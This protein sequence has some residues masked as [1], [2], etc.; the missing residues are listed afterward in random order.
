MIRIG[1]F[2]VFL[3]AAGAFAFAFYA[4]AA[5]FRFRGCPEQEAWQ[6]SDARGT[7]WVAGPVAT[8][9]VIA[10]MLAFRWRRTH[11]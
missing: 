9:F 1:L 3:S 5:D 2:F 8:A 7:M 10:S 11:A 4:A 6:C